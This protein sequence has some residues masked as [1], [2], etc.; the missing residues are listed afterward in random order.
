MLEHFLLGLTLGLPAA[1]QPGPLQT[2]LFS[3]T[4]RYGSRRT[5]PA[6]LAPLLSDG[7]IILI[8]LLLLS[9]VPPAFLR[10]LQLAGG[11][12]LF[13]LA[14]RTLASPPSDPVVERA[15]AASQSI[16]EATVL[17]LLN[18]NPYIFWTTVAGPIVIGAWRDSPVHA[19]VF[20]L[21]FYGLLVGGMAGLILFFGM[22][23]RLDVRL[24]RGLSVVSA[25]ALLLF[26]FYLLYQ[27]VIG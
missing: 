13:Q 14:W 9:Q 6:A 7:P 12:F 22:V 18:P 4:L 10:F 5:L 11:L 19:L 3:Q 16:V 23:E 26:G 1:L 17:N 15:E 8:V 2:Y 24:R 27:G 21:G 25:A 20:G